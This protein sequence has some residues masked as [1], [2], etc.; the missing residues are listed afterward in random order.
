MKADRELTEAA[1]FIDPESFW[2]QRIHPGTKHPC[3]YVRGRDVKPVRQRI[4]DRDG[5]RC[6]LKLKCDGTRVL[7]FDGDIYERWHLEHKEGGLG[8]QR[9]WCNE[10]LRGACFECHIAKDGRQPQWTK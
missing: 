9:C 6:T 10:N 7:S 4:Y 1:N 8:L 2:G 3:L 5:G